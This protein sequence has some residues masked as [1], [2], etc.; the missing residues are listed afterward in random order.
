M[1]RRPPRSTRTDTLFPYTT[2]FRSPLARTVSDIALFLSI[3]QGPDERDIQSLKPALDVKIPVPADARGLRIALPM[4]LGYAWVHPEVEAGVRGAADAPRDAGAVDAEVDLG[5]DW[6]INDR[7]W[8]GRLV[9]KSGV[10]KGR[11]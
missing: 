6:S 7:R 3:T 9:G 1:I 2:L 4:D 10:E 8:E 11:Y 5:W